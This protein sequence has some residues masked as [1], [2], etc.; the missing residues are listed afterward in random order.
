MIKASILAVGTEITSG[1]ILNRNSTWIAARLEELAIP[2]QSLLSVPDDREA[3]LTALVRLTDESQLVFVTG[4]LGPTTDDFTREVVAQFLKSPLEFREPSWNLLEEIYA[5]RG[6]PLRQAHRQQ[7][8]FPKGV[9]ILKN[10]VGTAEGFLAEAAAKKIFVLPG[11][12]RE[13]E[14]I[15][16]QEILPRLKTLGIQRVTELTKLICL[17]VP[18]S[19][20]AEIVEEVMKDQGTTLGYRA[21]FPYVHVKVW[22]PVG[23]S[24]WLTSLKDRLKPWLVGQGDTDLMQEWLKTLQSLQTVRIVDEATSGRL[25]ARLEALTRQ[26]DLSQLDLE[27]IMFWGPSVEYARDTNRDPVD[28]SFSVHSNGHSSQ[29]R[30]TAS[31]GA[32]AISRTLE[33]P[34]KINSSS[35]RGRIYM[36]EHAISMWLG[37][38]RQTEKGASQS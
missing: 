3:I 34:F 6:L 33:L 9:E 31:R 29:F 22:H 15:F 19:E 13:V 27:L 16:N 21:S 7:C 2:V 35:E 24:P 30:V 28:A 4:G 38:M 1:E 23:K 5:R 36:T 25:A 8:Y 37:F 26:M 32:Q 10:P 20:A 11:P 17:G 18:E 14:G 12:P